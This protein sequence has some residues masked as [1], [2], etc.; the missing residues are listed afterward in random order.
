MRTLSTALTL[1]LLLGLTVPASAIAATPGAPAPTSPPAGKPASASATA[2]GVSPGEPADNQA[3]AI[4]DVDVVLVSGQY[5][6]PG[7]WK[8]SKDE[9]ALWILGTVSPV[10]RKMDWY[11]PQAEEA[12]A[13][14]QEIVGPPGMGVTVGFG[15]AFKIA[16]AVPTILRARRNPD[17]KSLQDVLPQELYARWQVLKPLYLGDDNSV[18]QWRPFL[19]ADTLHQG[20]LKRS[21][22]AAGTGV[23]NRISELAKKHK[24]K[25]TSTTIVSAIKDPKKLA[26][27]LARED[28]DDVQ[29]FRSVL[30]RLELDVAN[31]AE[32]ANAWATGDI[33]ALTRLSD[34][35]NVLPCYE[36]LANTGAARSVGMDDAME[37]SEALW[38]K[39]A[40]AALTANHTSFAMLPVA[41]LLRPDGLLARLQA[42]GYDV[43][44]PE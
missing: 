18:E 25:W 43:V 26:K 5:S 6:G 34:R 12:L 22:L 8:V 13:R 17:G 24:I 20:A 16:F 19:A 14:T 37:R 41:Q 28:I 36:A 4:T 39:S 42:R 30:D 7:L 15:S 2:I 21:G 33:A 32:R 10:P 29:C 23:D 27:S 31:A 11:S 44:G 38:L 40:E 35:G 9:H 3:S 1:V